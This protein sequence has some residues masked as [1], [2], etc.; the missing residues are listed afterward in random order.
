ME[1]ARLDERLLHRIE[2][3]AFGKPFDRPHVRAVGEDGEEQAAR[4]RLAVDMNRTASAKA[5]PA[6]FPRAA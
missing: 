6:A 5:L 1:C 2:R 3:V 4:H